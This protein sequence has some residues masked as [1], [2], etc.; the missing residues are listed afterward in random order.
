[1]RLACLL[2]PDFILAALFRAEP[3]LR[4]QPVAVVRQSG[5][6]AL[7]AAVSPEAAGR[8]IAAGMSAAQA[9]GID[10]GLAVRL[11]GDDGRRAAQAALCD[12]AE[13]FS[14]RIEDAGDGVVYLDAGGLG[15]LFPTESAA[16][17]AMARRAER[18]GLEAHVGLAATKVAAHLAARDGGGVAVVPPGEEWSVLAPMP[19]GLL[20][21][22]PELA[23]SLRRWGLCTIGDL[24]SLPAAAVGARLGPEGAALV[25]RARGEDEHP[26]TPRPA[27]LSFEEGMEIDYGIDTL[28]PLAFVLRRLLDCL[29]A[30]LAVRGLVCGDLHLSLRLAGRARDARTVAVVAPSNDAKS[31]LT[32]LRLHL[33]AHP[34]AAAVEAV[35]LAA[36]PERLRAAQLDLFRPA[37]PSPES[38]AVTLA[39]LTALCGA[40]RV[41]VPVVADSHRPDAYGIAPFAGAGVGAPGREAQVPGSGSQVPGRGSEAPD[42]RS[43]D[44]GP[45][46]PVSPLALRAV[47]PPRGVEVHCDRGRLDFV[48]GEGIGGRVVHLAGPWRVQTDWWNEQ[49]ATRDYYDVQLS[50][51]GVYRLFCDRRRQAWFVDG[52]Y[53]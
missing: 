15:A 28:E 30:R 11:L 12:V 6:R 26:L 22:S 40:D 5:A 49:A 41:G 51:G 36:A 17:N 25:R 18:L 8:G 31:L 34:P 46:T 47:R 33:E 48:R 21:P 38:L 35:R 3:D 20:Q 19:I 9:R 42:S 50:D 13:S 16:A 10:D 29:V 43:P 53:D 23:R 45:G 7:V 44:S 1:M 4:G 14:P 52:L 24:A 32:L 27:L 2:L 39:R 37:G